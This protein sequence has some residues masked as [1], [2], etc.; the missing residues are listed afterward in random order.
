MQA[1]DGTV[2][3]KLSSRDFSYWGPAEKD[4]APRYFSAWSTEATASLAAMLASSARHWH[5]HDA[6][7][8]ERCLNAAEKAWKVLEAHPGRVEADLTAF[9]TGEYKAKDESHR[10][11]A[12]AELWETTGEARY[13][14][15]FE[16]LAADLDLSRQGPTWGDVQDLGFATYLLSSRAD[17]RQADLV[18]RLTRE[19]LEVAKEIVQTSQTGG[20][21]RPLGF[22]RK[23]WYWGANGTVAGQTLLLHLAD[24]LQPDPAYRATAEQALSFL[25][26][27]NYHAR[28]YVTGLGGLPPLHPHDRRGEPAWPG[29]LVGGGFPDGR[30]WKDEMPRYDLNEIAINWNG[31]LIYALAAFVPPAER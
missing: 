17:R 25:F 21:G 19:V 31:A 13:L 6:A 3:H 4:L 26:G 14:R 5:D 15:A 12:A 30:S 23:T 7:F 8:A 20:Y 2:H 24:R 22:A 28:S 1:E 27:R 16:S 18:R 10:L 9:K 11:W 29:Y